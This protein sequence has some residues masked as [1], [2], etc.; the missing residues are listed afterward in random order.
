MRTTPAGR[1]PGLKRQRGAASLLELVTAVTV[2][3]SLTAV[4]APRLT[5]LPTEARVAVIQSLEGTLHSAAALMHMKCAVKAPCDLQSGRFTLDVSG[6]VVHMLRGYPDAGHDLGIANAVLVT[7]FSVRHEA[8]RTVFTKDG[9]PRPDACAVV[10]GSPAFDGDQPA[11]ER[12]TA[13]C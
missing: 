13:G 8:G 3:G 6:D 7:G 2:A 4:A 5:G 1:R 9:A 11:I 12:L 10:Y